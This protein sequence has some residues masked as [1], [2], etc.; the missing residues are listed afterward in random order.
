MPRTC[1]LGTGHFL[2]TKVVTNGDLANLMTTS[3]EWIQQRTGIKL[4]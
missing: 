4:E 3:D 2:P 1:F